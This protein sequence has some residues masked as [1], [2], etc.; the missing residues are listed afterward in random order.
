MANYPDGM[1]PASAGTMELIC[2]NC[3]YVWEVPIV[4]DMGSTE[5]AD[6]DDDYC[7]NCDKPHS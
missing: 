1:P 2:D 7:P 4:N 6:S 5:L 3:S